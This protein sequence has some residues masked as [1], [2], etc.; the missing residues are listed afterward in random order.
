MRQVL[1]IFRKDVRMLWPAI[2]ATIALSVVSA[3]AA[4]RGIEDGASVVA[5]VFLLLSWLYLVYRAVHQERPAG[6]HEFWMTRPY[7]WRAVVGAKA[8]FVVVWIAIP[9]FLHDL[10]VL[11]GRGLPP[12]AGGIA[13]R[14]VEL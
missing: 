3:W 9:F 14:Q 11:S 4:A 6:D 2:A 7:D 12:A 8:L 5:P 1:H 10:A 13:V